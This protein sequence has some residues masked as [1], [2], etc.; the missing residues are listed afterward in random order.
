[1]QDRPWSCR[2]I[3]ALAIAAG[4]WGLVSI[5]SGQG[6]SSAPVRRPEPRLPSTA[7][8]VDTYGP[9]LEWIFFP[10]NPPVLGAEVAVVAASRQGNLPTTLRAFLTDPFFPQ[11]AARIVHF[12]GEEVRAQPFSPEE[13]VRLD[14][15]VSIRAALLKEIYDRSDQLWQLD[16]AARLVALGDMARAQQAR[17]EEIERTAQWLR[18]SLAKGDSWNEHREWRLERGSL[19]QPRDKTYVL[20]FQVV[21]A[22]AYY[23]EGFSPGQRTLVREL[24]IEMNEA[25]ALGGEQTVGSDLIMF[26][27]PDTARIRRPWTGSPGLESKIV[28]YIGEKRR[29]KDELR[30]IIYETDGLLLE[31][32]RTRR[33]EELARAQAEAIERLDEL[34]EEIRRELATVPDY[35]RYRG[36]SRLSARMEERLQAFADDVN[37]IEGDRAAFIRERVQRARDKASAAPAGAVVYES[38]ARARAVFEME[39]GNRLMAHERAAE[40]LLKDLIEELPP[41]ESGRLNGSAEIALREYLER[42]AEQDAYADYDLAVLEPGLSPAQRRLMLAASMARLRQVMLPPEKQ[43]TGAPGTLLGIGK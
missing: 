36:A 33:I 21:R 25:I 8:G 41:E 16:P 32:T 40:A 22:A 26:F 7:D 34:A 18:Q 23:Q 9:Q 42:R 31:Y 11:V 6:S 19:R 35:R 4:G 29:L 39:Q 28:G 30:E 43:P 17:L 3:L 38:A 27:S 15:F 20:E 5:A 13:F 14:S 12:E 2:W 10:V 37:R 24:A 1:M